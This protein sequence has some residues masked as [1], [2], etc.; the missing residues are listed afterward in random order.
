MTLTELPS[1]VQYNGNG[2]TKNFAIPFVFFD[3]S[4]IVVK[5]LVV[6]TG[7]ETTIVSGFTI[8][9]AGSNPPTGSITYT[10]APP[11]G[12]RVTI[13]RDVDYNQNANYRKNEGFPSA[14]HETQMDRQVAQI[15]QLLE[16]TKRSLKFVSSVITTFNAQLP[17][18]TN[19][20][21]RA[22]KIN[23][24]ADGLEYSN[25][26]I[27]NLDAAI[28]ACDAAAA[29][30]AASASSAA[31][32]EALINQLTP[33][34]QATPNNTVLIRAG[35][36]YDLGDLTASPLAVAAG[37]ANAITFPVIVTDPRIDLLVVDDAGTWSRVAGVENASPVPPAY[38]TDKYVIAEVTIDEDTTVVINDAD[39]RN[40]THVVKGPSESTAITYDNGVSGLAATN[41]KAAIDELA[42]DDFKVAT[43]TFNSDNTNNRTIS[44]GIPGGSTV[45]M[46]HV[47]QLA[48]AVSSTWYKDHANHNSANSVFV[49]ATNRFD[50]S[51]V[52]FIVGTLG[53]NVGV[54]NACEWIVFYK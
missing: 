42:G 25:A 39:I 14:E 2:S 49:N 46:V 41:V 44:T 22:L 7:V 29:A 33:S 27:D 24:T 45:L 10:T 11:T 5:E 4:E 21:G 51:G 19:K 13:E 1:R 48:N 28:A 8:A 26:D 12:T 52:D 38:P 36:L 9:G 23:G 40:V 18:P 54:S 3:D 17:D 34:E 6:A 20:A 37:A 30:A 50:D 43:G 16:E 15:Q 47:K 53:V 31:A 32:S 35:Y